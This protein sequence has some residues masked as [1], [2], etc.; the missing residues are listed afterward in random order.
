MVRK[1][2]SRYPTHYIQLYDYFS[3]EHANVDYGTCT[4]VSKASCKE[5]AKSRG[6]GMSV[7]RETIRP[8]AAIINSHPI[9]CGTIRHQGELLAMLIVCAFVNQHMVSY[10]LFMIT[11]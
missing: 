1:I 11:S 5:I 3:V 9:I 4:S 7:T 8:V 6:I 2:I 10:F